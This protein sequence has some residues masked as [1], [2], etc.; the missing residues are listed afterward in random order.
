MFTSNEC[1][2]GCNV[3]SAVLV[4]VLM[5]ALTAGPAVATTT[6]GTNFDGVLSLI[7]DDSS[8]NVFLE[9]GS[10]L[11]PGTDHL[12]VSSAGN[13]FL[14]GN[15]NLPAF[16]PTVTVTSN[17][18]S[19]ID[20]SWSGGDFL[21]TGSFLGNILGIGLTEAA[22]LSDLTILWGGSSTPF[23]D[24]DLIHGTYGT[25]PGNPVLPGSGSN[26]F[27]RFFD[28]NSGQFFDPP[29]ATGFEYN[30]GGGSL[31]TKLGLP[32]GY[33]NSFDVVVGGTTVASGLA[34]GMD[35]TFAGSGVSNFSLVGIDPAVDSADSNAFPLYLEF[36]TATA[37]FDMMAIPEP[38]TMGMLLVGALGLIRR[39]K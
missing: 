11:S 20:I 8:G 29:L 39:R 9:H 33:G 4:G 34:G 15:L 27:W 12:V 24:G 22:L 37:S 19:S 32:M 13:L 30:M 35:Y 1:I 17:T 6:T 2:F 21:G 7:Y 10:L 25:M 14:P 16:P 26:G 31:F 36:S 18:T 3:R 28:V 23:G 38:A 5:M